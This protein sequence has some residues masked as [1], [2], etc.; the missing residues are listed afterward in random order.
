MQKPQF[1]IVVAADFGKIFACG[2]DRIA[3]FGRNA[4]PISAYTRFGGAEA[5]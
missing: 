2:E 1:Q 4:I 3:I 5:Q